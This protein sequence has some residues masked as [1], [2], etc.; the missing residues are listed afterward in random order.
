MEENP[1]DSKLGTKYLW[2]PLGTF[3]HSFVSVPQHLKYF[4]AE[5]SNYV[6]DIIRLP[7]F[8]MLNCQVDIFIPDQRILYVC[9]L[10]CL[11]VCPSQNFGI[12]FENP[13]SQLTE[14][15]NYYSDNRSIF[16][17][18]PFLHSMTTTNN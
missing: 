15:C 5:S 4:S 12:V 11:S 3:Q 10:I 9:L 16:K 7:S 13:I 2:V 1:A 18:H 14:A 8:L 6:N 17:P